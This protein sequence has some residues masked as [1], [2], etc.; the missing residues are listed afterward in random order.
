MKYFVLFTVLLVSEKLLGQQSPLA[1]KLL[2]TKHLIALW[3]FKE[4]KGEKRKS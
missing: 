1:N 3:D 4:A 2:K